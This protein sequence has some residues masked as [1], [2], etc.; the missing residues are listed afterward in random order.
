MGEMLELGDFSVELHREIG[1][2]VAAAG[3]DC[4]LGVGGAVWEAVDAARQAGMSGDEARFFADRETLHAY[5][6]RFL[7]PGDAVLVKGSR[8]TGM[9]EVADFIRNDLMARRR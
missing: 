7:G 6:G 5:L 1:A 4:L 2:E 3:V 9:D 8:A